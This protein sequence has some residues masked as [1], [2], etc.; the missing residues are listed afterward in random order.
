M[1]EE[2]RRNTP[3]SRKR[4][5]T[6]LKAPKR[7][8][9]ENQ[10]KTESY[11]DDKAKRATRL[12]EVTLQYTKIPMTERH[13]QS[14]QAGG[15]T[16]GTHTQANAKSKEEVKRQQKWESLLKQEFDQEIEETRTGF[17]TATRLLL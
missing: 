16:M 3:C 14:S 10:V 9:M 2:D 1:E 11:A 5:R 17:M 15:R 6:K 13:N 7:P 4:S 8:K 12:K